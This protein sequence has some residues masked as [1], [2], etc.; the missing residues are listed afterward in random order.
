[1]LHSVERM[2]TSVRLLI[3]KNDIKVIVQSVSARGQNMLNSPQAST[4][5]ASSIS[6]GLLT[7]QASCKWRARSTI[8]SQ[9]L[10][11]DFLLSK[12]IIWFFLNLNIIAYICV[13]SG[14]FLILNTIAYICVDSDMELLPFGSPGINTYSFD[15]IEY[16]WTDRY[17]SSLCKSK[18]FFHFISNF[19]FKKVWNFI[20]RLCV[21]YM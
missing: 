2:P 1:M 4:R 13:D 16:C 15:K 19:T 11:I 21:Q 3:I 17:I 10:P 8:S 6:R 14:F 7:A 20:K 12:T 18:L 9:C 5:H